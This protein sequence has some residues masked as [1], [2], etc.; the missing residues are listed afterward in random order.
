MRDEPKTIGIT[1]VRASATLPPQCCLSE[2]LSVLFKPRHS[3]ARRFH[4]HFFES[5]NQYSFTFKTDDDGQ[6][7]HEMGN[8]C[9]DNTDEQASHAQSFPWD[10]DS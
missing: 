5:Y 4:S 3:H 6:A 10:I 8:I 9:D 7:T 1:D 2:K